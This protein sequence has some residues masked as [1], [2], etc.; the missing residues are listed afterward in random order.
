VAEGAARPVRSLSIDDYRLLEEESGLRHECVAGELNGAVAV[1]TGAL[2]LLGAVWSEA[3]LAVGGTVVGIDRPGVRPPAAVEA[4]RARFGADRL[5]L[6]EADILCRSDLERVRDTLPAPPQVLVNNAGIDAP[7]N[8]EAPRFRLDEIPAD[9]FRRILDVNVFGTFQVS[10]IIGSCM[11][12]RGAGL[13]STLARSTPASRPTSA[14]TTTS[15]L[16]RPS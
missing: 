10:Q 13:S 11:P 6:F 4:L 5:Q 2:G 3:L 1:V 8:A 14:S 16:I 7:P 15:P 12:R 9:V